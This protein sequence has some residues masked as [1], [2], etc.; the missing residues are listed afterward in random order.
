MA[1]SARWCASLLFYSLAGLAAAHAASGEIDRL[2]EELG[3]GRF[4][5]PSIE[6]VFQELTSLEPIPFDR[7]WRPLPDRLPQD[8]PRMALLAGNLLADGFLVVEDQRTSKVSTVGHDLVRL[9][10]GLGIGD[11]ITKRGRHVIDL[12]EKD[13]WTEMRHELVKTQA[14]VEAALLGLKDEDLVHLIALGGWLRGLEIT[15]GCVAD[16]YTADRA[17]RLFQPDV[18]AKFIERIQGFR[19]RLRNSMLMQTVGN[20][21]RDIRDVAAEKQPNRPY[22]LAQVK[23]I[24]EATRDA[25]SAISDVE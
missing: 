6:A 5:A 21:L 23:R 18:A 17:A 10:K 13:R 24:H 20:D 8:R 12:A 22:T 7:V 15:S 4:M 19:P 25:D 3:I 1:S 11:K 16:D 2:R 9:A 14:E